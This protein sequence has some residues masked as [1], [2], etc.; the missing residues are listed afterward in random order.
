MVMQATGMAV[1][2]DGVSVLK[3]GVRWSEL[4]SAETGS[5]LTGG[6]WRPELNNTEVGCLLTGDVRRSSHRQL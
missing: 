6:V 4:T 1:N 5:I 2:E 3:D